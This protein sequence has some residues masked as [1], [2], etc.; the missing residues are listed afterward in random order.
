MS[1]KIFV[2]LPVNDLD[3]SIAFF[4]EIGFMVNP[5][6]TDATAACLVISEE[7]YVM[8]LTHAKMKP[9]TPKPIADATKTTEVLVCLNC[10][11]RTEVDKTVNK[12]LAAGGTQC[13]EPIDHGF[14]YS[15]D[16]QDP[17]GHIWGFLWMDPS[18]VQQQQ[19]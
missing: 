9:F 19:Q 13:S 10:E 8:L 14:M 5:Q 1:R 3:K 12:A 15:R 7:I 17:D 4:R 2:N 11:S 6:F 16:F 18:V